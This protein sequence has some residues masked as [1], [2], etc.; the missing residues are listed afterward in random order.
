MKSLAQSSMLECTGRY[1]GTQEETQR[2]GEAKLE[3]LPD[4]EELCAGFCCVT[5]VGGLDI[6]L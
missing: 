6:I 4:R 5:V 2:K 1:G 3:R